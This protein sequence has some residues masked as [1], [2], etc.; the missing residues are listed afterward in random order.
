MKT[1]LPWLVRHGLN[2][3]ADQHRKWRTQHHTSFAAC[4]SPSDTSP[5][6][7]EPLPLCRPCYAVSPLN[8]WKL[9]QP[10]T[11]SSHVLCNVCMWVGCHLSPEGEHIAVLCMT[12]QPQILRQELALESVHNII[13]HNKYHYNNHT[14]KLDT[15]L[16]VTLSG[17]SA[18]KHKT[19]KNFSITSALTWSWIQLKMKEVN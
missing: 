13:I 1:Q 6:C 10:M 3:W 7:W 12:L 14:S 11:H 17:R 19:S 4:T 5:P 16:I 9:F 8:G 15:C 18:F 2:H